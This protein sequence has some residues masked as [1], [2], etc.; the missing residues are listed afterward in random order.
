MITSRPWAGAHTGFLCVV[1]L[2]AFGCSVHRRDAAPTASAGVAA[3]PGGAAAV[4]GSAAND[5]GALLSTS[6]RA[7]LAALCAQR[8]AE[9]RG[10][11]GYRLG[12]DDLIEVRI[13]DLLEAQAPVQAAAAG[14]A[15]MGRATVAGAPAFQQGLRVDAH[16]DVTIAS[17]GAVPVAGLTPSELEKDLARRLVRGGILDAPQVSVLVVEYRSRVAHVVGS[18]ERPG[19]YPITSHATSVAD[20]IGLAGGPT[21]EAGRVVQFTPVGDE[22]RG[23]PAPASGVA[24]VRMDLELLLHAQGPGSCDLD[25]PARP[26]DVISVSPAG[27]VQVTGWV[28][29]PGSVPVTR[30]LTVSG[31]IAAVGGNVFAADQRQVLVKRTLSAGEE[32]S[33]VVDL[34]AVA[35]G[36]AKDVTLTDGDLVTVPSDTTK[37]VPYGVWTFAKEMIHV[38]GSIPLF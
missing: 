27:T 28:D 33:I 36:R 30:G 25:P 21:R 38:G 12:P 14:A 17:L 1:V 34:D 35:E 8:S 13:P 11:D 29:K 31:A 22:P 24:P 3:A 18:V 23:V 10:S 20:L 16:G 4:D 26:G 15:T 37:L 2:V 19:V 32:R 6:D 9:P 5:G 7:R